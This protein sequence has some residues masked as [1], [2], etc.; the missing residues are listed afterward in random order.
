MPEGK[1]LDRIV[2]FSGVHGSGKSTLVREIANNELYLEHKRIHEVILEDTYIRALWRLTKYYIE[3]REQVALAGKD[4]SQVVLGN[5]CVYDN[6]A[7]M[8]AFRR[9]NWVSDEDVRQH[10]D[11]FEALFPENLRPKVVVYLA[12]PYEW[13]VERLD[14][15]WQTE[16]KKW[17]ENDFEYLSSVMQAFENLYGT[18]QLGPILPVVPLKILRLEETNLNERVEKVLDWLKLLRD[19][20]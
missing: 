9:L 10:S 17:R 15:R 14:E 8:N 4:A 6:F 20:A 16:K 7:Y 12:P 19:L 18:M 1:M 11:V 13:V 5:R 2:Y 3:A